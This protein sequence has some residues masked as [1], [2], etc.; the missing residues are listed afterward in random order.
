MFQQ[1]VPE[2]E[3]FAPAFQ[4]FSAQRTIRLR[5]PIRRHDIGEQKIDF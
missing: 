5:F 2:G 4:E 3:L 1:G